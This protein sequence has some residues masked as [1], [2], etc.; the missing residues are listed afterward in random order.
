MCVYRSVTAVHGPPT[1]NSAHQHEQRVVNTLAPQCTM[2]TLI[3]RF[4]STELAYGC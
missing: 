4:V 3:V 1:L 2:E